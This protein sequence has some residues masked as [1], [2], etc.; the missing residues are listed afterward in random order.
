VGENIS[1]DDPKMIVHTTYGRSWYIELSLI[2]KAVNKNIID[3]C[4][5]GH[6]H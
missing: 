5:S 4:F 3:I 6:R 1:N 2:F